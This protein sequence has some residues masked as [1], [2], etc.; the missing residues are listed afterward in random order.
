VFEPYNVGDEYGNL[1][2]SSKI[3][4]RAEADEVLKLA[5]QMEKIGKE[6]RAPLGWEILGWS[7]KGGE[8]RGK[9]MRN[10]L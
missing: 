7:R 8:I 3:I 2:K 6:L 10:G 9:K 1:R 4:T 5:R